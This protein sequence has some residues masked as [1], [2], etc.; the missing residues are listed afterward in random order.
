MREILWKIEENW[1]FSQSLDQKSS[2]ATFTP[3]SRNDAPD[4][5]KIF[6]AMRSRTRNIASDCGGRYLV[7]KGKRHRFRRCKNFSRH[8]AE[9]AKYRGKS[10]V[11]GLGE[12]Q[13]SKLA[14]ML[15]LRFFSCENL[16]NWKIAAQIQKMQELSPHD[17]GTRYRG[18]SM[19]W[20]ISRK[21]AKFTLPQIRKIGKNRR[22]ATRNSLFGQGGGL[23][24]RNVK[25]FTLRCR[26]REIGGKTR[27][28]RT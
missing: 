4:S 2:V 13:G 8:N 12:K 27:G 14:K 11:G 5:E 23:H 10:I 18:K 16:Q 17:A 15:N 1:K 25:I 21:T 3:Q 9:T 24:S 28:H 6:H 19:T 20:R 26:K 22:I 7:R